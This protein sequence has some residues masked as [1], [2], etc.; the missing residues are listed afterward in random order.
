MQ[1]EQ[2]DQAD[3]H[4]GSES[5]RRKVGRGSRSSATRFTEQEFLNLCRDCLANYGEMKI[6]KRNTPNSI[7]LIT[8]YRAKYILRGSLNN[9]SGIFQNIK[10]ILQFMKINSIYE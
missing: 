8:F 9:Q 5:L 6:R 7:F 2:S 3:C 1:I 4:A 10:D